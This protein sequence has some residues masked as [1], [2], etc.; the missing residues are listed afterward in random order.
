[1]ED[2][3]FAHPDIILILEHS[4]NNICADCG[5]K[6]VLWC[7]V[8]NGVFLC[9]KCARNHKKKLKLYSIIKSL[10]ADLFNDYEINLLKKGGNMR[11]NN[12]MT[13]YN[14]PLSND[15]K[16]YKYQTLIS[17]YYRKLLDNEVKGIKSLIKKPSLQ[18][19]ILK[20]NPEIYNNRIFN[21][22]QYINQNNINY[23]HNQ[24]INQQINYPMNQNINKNF[25]NM[26]EKSEI[27]INYYNPNYNSWNNVLSSM[28]QMFN[29]FIKDYEIDK[30]IDQ[31]NEY[32]NEKKIQIS[33]SELFQSMKEK[34]EN[35]IQIIKEKA[36]ELYNG[37]RYDNEFDHTKSSDIVEM[38]NENP[39]K[40]NEKDNIISNE[41]NKNNNRQN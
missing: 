40:E 21:N 31:A 11:F 9:V 35:G 20:I 22:N 12:L 30:K 38:P 23:I 25:N 26:P 28:G 16:E 24:N 29:T 10:E 39:K 32:I 41:N 13:E 37:E 2:N 33:N 1:M 17:G 8:N 27:N 19:G 7:S 15:M 4:G 3:K 36:S 34:A 5:N 6:K 14:I 18:D